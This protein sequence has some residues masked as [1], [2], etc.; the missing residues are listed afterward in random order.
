M[1]SD[2]NSQA[3]EEVD[4]LVCGAGAGGMTAALVAALEGLDVVLCEKTAQAGGTTST[5][6][7]T[8][9]VPGTHLSEQAGVPD[10]VEDARA[11]LEAVVANRGGAR[12]REAFLAS[13]RDA[14]ADLDR[15]TD[16]KFVAAAAHPDYLDGPGAAYGGR[17]LA[18]VTFDG[19]R[20]GR[21]DFDRVRPPRREFMGLGGMMVGRNELGA[22]LAPFA[23]A[24]HLRD[25]IT[26]VGR[27]VL[28]RLRY[29]RGTRLLMGNALVARLLYSLR[30]AKVPVLFETGVRELLVEEGRVVGA[31]L[32]GPAGPRRIRAR[33]GVVLATGGVGWNRK[34]RERLFPA[35]TRDYS[36]A[37]ETNTGDGA[38]V[39][40]AIG[41]RFEDG[42]DSPALWMPCS[43][44]R[45]PD[46]TL[47]VWPHIILD[48]A[49]PG[50]LAV[51]AA[52]RRFVNESDSYHDFSME[53]ISTGAIPAHLVCD[54]AF[55]RRYGM[56]MVLP[57][58]SNLPAMLKAGYVTEAR[59]LAELA[60][61]IGCDP[62]ALA[63]TVDAYNRAAAAGIDEAF[64]RGASVVNRF[65]GDPAVGPNPCLGPV[66]A[67]PYYAI[68]V[69]PA[70]LASSAGLAGDEYGRVLDEA[71][72]PIA[73]LYACG[74]DLA[75]IFR[76]TYPGPGTTIGPAVVFGWR[77]ARH[78]AGTLNDMPE[79]PADTMKDERT[80]H[81]TL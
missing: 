74:N 29:R 78:A 50:L 22:L 62:Q 69:R 54:A 71:G 53:Q 59:T 31:V 75:S 1:P 42:G 16:V 68:P 25:A 38:D 43:S 36:L 60:E 7:G 18:P 45:R 57:G 80:N 11:F 15:R 64:G 17:A 40:T 67:G 76:G 5:S 47:A 56:G 28:D 24:A 34:I 2:R 49:K 3:I 26:I 33:K 14:I 39:A 8:T 9:W 37:P 10:R 13:G 32:S 46:G 30:K 66:G 19:R 44:Y 35:G 21:A 41:A 12:L 6:G 23:S 72:E 20:L 4:L 48:R 61:K 52:G 73:G 81:A 70:D 65:N 79:T 77:V 58:A 55:M 27:Y 51:N 63:E